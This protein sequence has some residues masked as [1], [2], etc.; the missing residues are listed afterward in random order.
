M[1]TVRPATAT[2]AT[3]W[4]GVQPDRWRG[5]GNRRSFVAEVDAELVGHCRGIDND[6]HPASRVLVLEVEPAHR[7]HGVGTALLAAQVGVSDR[8]LRAKLT[9]EMPAALALARR[10]GA[11][12]EQ[13]CPPWR[14]NIDPE[15]RAWA[16]AHRDAGPGLQ[17]R[18]PCPRDL[19]ALARLATDH[20]IAQHAG[21]SPA[22]D[23]ETLLALTME[24]Y[25]VDGLDVR[26][27]RVAVHEGRLVAAAH[28]G[29][30]VR[31][32]IRHPHRATAP[33]KR[34]AKRHCVFG[35]EIYA[36]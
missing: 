8:P 32:A 25:T 16:D 20:Y 14:R 11:V 33:H 12:V 22:A 21:W 29:H 13:A 23:R 7:G 30:P 31:L 18:P 1:L 15:V 4:P 24:D 9:T 3:V 26:L 10:F 27:S 36:A 2:D 28:G 19:P 6:V 34:R 35:T 5:G 17:I